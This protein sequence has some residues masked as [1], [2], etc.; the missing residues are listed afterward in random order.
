MDKI[1]VFRESDCQALLALYF[2]H[3]MKVFLIIL[4]FISSSMLLLIIQGCNE[5]STVQ[6]PP[7]A[8]IRFVIVDDKGNSLVQGPNAKYSADSIRLIN[9][10]T[11][12]DGNIYK[13]EYIESLKNIL[14]EADSHNSSGGARYSIYISTSLIQ[15]L[16]LFPTR[17]T[18]QSALHIRLILNSI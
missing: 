2:Q 16:L 11:G 6:P 3:I 1:K 14:F 7:V 4:V 18:K 17:N 12:F 13:K 9:S 15:T 5:C 10:K 8:P